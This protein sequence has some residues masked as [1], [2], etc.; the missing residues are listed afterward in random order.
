MQCR[1]NQQATPGDRDPMVQG[2]RDLARECAT[3][4]E[5]EVKG[6]EEEVEGTRNVTRVVIAATEIEWS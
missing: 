6:G 5:S 4:E 3:A 2:E 1:Y